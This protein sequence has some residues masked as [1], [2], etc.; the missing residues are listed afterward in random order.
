[1][2]SGMAIMMETSSSVDIKFVGIHSTSKQISGICTSTNSGIGLESVTGMTTLSI[3]VLLPTEPNLTEEPELT[4]RIEPMQ[5]RN[6]TFRCRFIHNYPISLRSPFNNATPSGVLFLPERST[7]HRLLLW[8][9]ECPWAAMNTYYLV[10]G[11][12]VCT[13]LAFEDVT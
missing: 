6:S 10:A 11:K 3:P 13:S 2:R 7:T 9:C 8:A 5:T 12:L 1:M 4:S